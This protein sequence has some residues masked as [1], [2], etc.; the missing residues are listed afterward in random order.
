MSIVEDE[1]KCPICMILSPNLY[2][3][4][5]MWRTANEMSFSMYTGQKIVQFSPSSKCVRYNVIYKHIDHM[6]G[7]HA[8]IN[9]MIHFSDELDKRQLRVHIRMHP[10]VSN[11]YSLQLCQAS[12]KTPN[13]NWLGLCTALLL[14]HS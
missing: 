13:G 6:Q 5:Y 2:T 12:Y 4:Y 10:W 7:C 8:Y 3:G 14:L 9:V 1:A 11:N